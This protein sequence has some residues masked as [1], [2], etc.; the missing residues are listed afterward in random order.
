LLY[1]QS[2]YGEERAGLVNE[3]YKDNSGIG[4]LTKPE[5]LYLNNTNLM[6]A[7]A[8][9]NVNIGNLRET[10]FLNQF[11]GLHQINRSNEAD[12]II[13]KTHTFEIGGKS[14]SKKQIAGLKN[15]YVAKD[16]IE[17]GFGNIIPVWLFGFMY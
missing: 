4:V 5:K 11:K 13:N 8:K 12:F 10:F 7:L 6:Y 16:A 2:V 17:I 14:K 1:K 9:E 15:A 3:L